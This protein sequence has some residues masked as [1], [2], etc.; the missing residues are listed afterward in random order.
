[1]KSSSYG[2]LRADRTALDFV[3]L[4]KKMRVAASQH[5]AQTSRRLC[6]LI[7]RVGSW[8]LRMTMAVHEFWC[9]WSA[10]NRLFDRNARLIELYLGS[11]RSPFT[12]ARS[13]S[14]TAR[15]ARLMG[16]FS[17][18]SA[19][20]SRS[21]FCEGEDTRIHLRRSVSPPAEEPL[22]VRVRY[23]CRVTIPQGFVFQKSRSAMPDECFLIGR[24]STRKRQLADKLF[25]SNAGALLFQSDSRNDEVSVFCD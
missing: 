25:Q 1:M 8:R 19:A 16:S 23:S 18:A 2:M 21:A 4:V 13:A 10:P 9:I 6:A 22:F 7:V 20:A 5:P 15:L 12:V 11:L 3:R 24:S 14:W 17:R